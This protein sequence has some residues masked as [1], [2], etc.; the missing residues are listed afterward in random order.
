MNNNKQIIISVTI[1]IISFKY[2]HKSIL[3]GDDEQ[4]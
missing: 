2:I 4:S 1:M 3:Y